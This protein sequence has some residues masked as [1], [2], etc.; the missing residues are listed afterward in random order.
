MQ[1]ENPGERHPRHRSCLASL[2]QPERSQV[3]ESWVPPEE[4][5]W[6]QTPR[7]AESYTQ[8]VMELYLLFQTFPHQPFF[9][10]DLGTQLCLHVPSLTEALFIKKDGVDLGVLGSVLVSLG[11]GG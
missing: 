8:G 1:P 2:P 11:S 4:G 6:F 3:H 9:W 7:P 5:G 10:K